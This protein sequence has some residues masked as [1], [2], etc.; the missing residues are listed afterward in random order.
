MVNMVM[1]VEY[2]ILGCFCTIC[3]LWKGNDVMCT[4]RLELELKM[5]AP[6]LSALYVRPA[7]S[8]ACALQNVIQ[9]SNKSSQ[10]IMD[11]GIAPRATMGHTPCIPQ[12]SASVSFE[13]LN[14]KRG[15]HMDHQ[16][17]SSRG[18]RV[19]AS[20]AA[21]ETAES[22]KVGHLSFLK[23]HFAL[24]NHNSSLL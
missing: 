3:N 22:P 21:V 15:F 9:G 4:G 8:I 20:A 13:K 10:R 23:L 24:H 14:Q 11:V 1:S 5:A 18:M 6:A 12:V 7:S 17:S 19:Q 2:L 16:W